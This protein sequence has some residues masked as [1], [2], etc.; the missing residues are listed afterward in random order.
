M[1]SSLKK[2]F[3]LFLLFFLL[4][5]SL[6]SWRWAT[7]GFR[8]NKISGPLPIIEKINFSTEFSKEELNILNQKFRYFSKGCQAFVF[9]SEDD[10]YV[11]KFLA[12]QKYNE[13]FRR[14]LLKNFHI[15]KQYR[16]GRT[17]NRSRNFKS[18][19][20]SYRIAFEKLKEETAIINMHFCKNNLQ[21]QIT[22]LDNLGFS[23]K[24]DLGSAYFILQKKAKTLKSI[25]LENLG[26]K[27]F[28]AVDKIMK[29]YLNA[30]YFSLRKGILNKDSSVKN[31]GYINDR[32]IEFDLGRF[33][34]ADLKEFEKHYALYTRNFRKFLILNAPNL[35]KDFDK[36]YAEHLKEFSKSIP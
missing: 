1:K 8:T 12:L 31:S 20:Q 14:K 7:K 35:L 18:A 26:K 4:G 30:S 10:R 17:F 36:K 29:D 13:P 32:F 6:F 5:L 3:Y 22:L 24:I 34:V 15:F 9:V 19:L 33:Q 27:D 21:K 2:A 23:H 11:L 25:L 16:E 28:M